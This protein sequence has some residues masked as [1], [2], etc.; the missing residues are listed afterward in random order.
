MGL[1]SVN[2]QESGL[3]AAQTGISVIGNNL[4]NS[5]TVG[6]QSSQTLFDDVLT[7]EMGESS[8]PA[9]GQGVEVQAVQTQFTQGPLQ[10]TDNPLDFAITGAGFFIVKD[11]TT[12]DTSYT[13]NGEFSLDKNGDIVNDSGQILQGYLANSSGTISQSLT[14]LT[15]PPDS[16]GNLTIPAQA[17]STAAL[18]VNLDSSDTV[19]SA[20]FA[21]NFSST[22][23]PASG[24]YD[25][26]ASMNVYDS[27]GNSHQV[28]VYF[29]KA[30]SA[31]G[32]SN[33]STWNAYA[34]WNTAQP[35]A[36]GNITNN[37]QYQQL[38]DM[39]F[40][41]STN[42]SGQTVSTLTSPA[43]AQNVNLTWDPS[44]GATSPQTVS[45]SF[46]GSTQ[47]ASTDSTMSQTANGYAQG[48][49]TSFNLNADGTLEGI[50]SNGQEQT[51]A[52]VVLAKFNAPTQLT[53]EGNNLYAQTY[54]SGAPIL[55]T[56]G[57][58]GVGTV[59]GD[60]LEGSNVDPV[61]EYTNLI[62]YQQSFTSNATV[63]TTTNEMFTTML[64]E[65]T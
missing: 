48:G 8:V 4:A 39:T 21:T 64:S 35:D 14:N 59:T 52:Q 29:A 56:P 47:Y 46:A 33:T 31:G 51:V 7:Q 22:S 18:S 62:A 32:A 26:S 9:S 58:G 43:A 38:G 2:I 61:T 12:G 20:D 10:T 27:A 23:G 63:I 19:P 13:R 3:N 25:Y 53:N 45:L 57:T 30:A 40:S 6:F 15:L 5:N 34:V 55:A 60:S 44:W 28:T 41:T 16:T 24:T 37:Y 1:S 17:T 54:G 11:P 42:S 50:Y 49:L 65:T 36:N